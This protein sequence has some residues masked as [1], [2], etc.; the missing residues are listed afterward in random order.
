MDPYQ[1][2]Y[3]TLY[4]KLTELISEMQEAQQLTEEIFLM[5]EEGTDDDEAGH[6]GGE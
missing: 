5:H 3:Y 4:N 2:M 6:A 1:Q